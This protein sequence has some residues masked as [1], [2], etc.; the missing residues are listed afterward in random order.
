MIK[1]LGAV[2]FSLVLAGCATPQSEAW[3]RDFAGLS[4]RIAQYHFGWQLSGDPD[5]APLQVFDDGTDIWLQYPAGQAVPAVFARTPA[6]DTLLR[7]RRDGDYLRVRGVHSHLLMRGGLSMAE[8]RRQGAGSGVVGA[9]VAPAPTPAPVVLPVA[10]VAPVAAPVAAPKPVAASAPRSVPTLM[11]SRPSGASQVVQAA[12]PGTAPGA[13]L[14]PAS[15][16]VAQAAGLP[17]DGKKQSFEVTP[18]D[19]NVRRALGRWARQAGWTFEP[20][21]WAVDVDIPLAGSAE[22]DEPFR[23]AVR[24][25]L[26][27]TELGDRPVQPCFYANQVMRVVPLAQ[28]CDRT[29]LGGES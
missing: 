23:S 4:P 2:C 16:P 11:P 25:L 28:R 18:G 12:S 14:A 3:W 6:G 24:S 7:A 17:V 10:T 22:F 27:A 1:I 9:S 19:G 20:E 5:L 8:A 29:Q 15:A 13:R 26:A 21:H